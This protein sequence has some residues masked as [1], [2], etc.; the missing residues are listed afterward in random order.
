VKKAEEDSYQTEGVEEE[1]ETFI[2]EKSNKF[3]IVIY[4][5]HFRENGVLLF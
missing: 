4:K 3:T 2:G 1:I 5:P